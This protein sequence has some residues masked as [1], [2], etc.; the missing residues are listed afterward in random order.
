MCQ[1]TVVRD[2]WQ[3]GQELVVHGWVYGLQNGLLKDLHMTISRLD[4]ATVAYDAAI[5][6]V[7][8]RHDRMARIDAAS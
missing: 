7:R 4:D 1:T 5:A 3:R 6:A 2:A 8:A